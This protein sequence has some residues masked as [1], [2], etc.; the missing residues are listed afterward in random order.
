MIKYIK[1]IYNDRNNNLKYLLYIGLN[2]VAL[3][4]IALSEFLRA[5]NVNK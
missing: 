5:L 1:P 3:I 4:Y 2:K